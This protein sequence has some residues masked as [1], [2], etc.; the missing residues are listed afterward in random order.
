[1]VR[2][3]TAITPCPNR[4]AWSEGEE[5]KDEKVVTRKKYTIER[6]KERLKVDPTV[7]VETGEKSFGVDLVVKG[8]ES[9]EVERRFSH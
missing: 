3:T 1:M 2:W 8:G 4:S 6:I 7:M 9:E 5:S